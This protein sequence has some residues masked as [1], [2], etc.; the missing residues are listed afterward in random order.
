MQA[1]VVR[2]RRRT[3]VYAGVTFGETEFR[4]QVRSRIQFEE[5][6]GLLAEHA[7]LNKAMLIAVASRIPTIDPATWPNPNELLA[8]EIPKTSFG[9]S[10]TAQRAARIPKRIFNNFHDDVVC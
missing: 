4:R 10:A 2:P 3:F 8:C 6:G 1:R 9:T 7:L 5:G